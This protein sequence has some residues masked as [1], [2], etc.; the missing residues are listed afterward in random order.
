MLST[1]EQLGPYRILGPIGAGG[2]GEVYKASDTRLERTVAL[3]LLPAHWA[4]NLE[5]RQRFE[6]EAQIVASLNHPNICILHDI[7]RH[8]GS[9]FLVMEYLEGETLA[10]RIERGHIPWDEALHIAIA[11]ADALDKAHR[12]GVVHRDLKP[13]NIILAESGPKLLDFGLAKWN[14]PSG[15]VSSAPPTSATQM[16]TRSDVTMP[17]SIMGTLQYMAPEQLEG[18][19]TDA[20]TDIFAFGSI[21]QEMLT[22]KK[23]FEGKSRVLLMS[24]IASAEPE[25]PSQTQPEIP[26]ALEHIL[27]VC[28]AKEPRDRWQTT[29]DLLAEL[30]WVARAG[31]DATPSSAAPAARGRREWL[32][33]WAPAAAVALAA[34]AAV[35]AALS[36]RATAPEEIRFHVPISTSPRPANPVMAVV[37]G[38][39]QN[40]AISPDGRN[41]VYRAEDNNATQAAA[42]FLRLTGSTAT[43]RLAGTENPEQ[44]FW[45]ADS[46]FVGYAVGSKLFKVEASGG[47]PQPICEAPGFA[48]AAWNREGVILFATAGGLSRVSAEGGKPEKV[49][50]MEPGESAHLWPLFLPDGHHYLFTVLSADPAKHGIFEGDLASRTKARLLPVE[51]NAFYAEPGFLVFGRQNAVYAQPFSWKSAAVSGEPAR[52]ADNVPKAPAGRGTFSVS[53]DGALA[54][55]QVPS[56]RTGGSGEAQEWQAAWVDRTGLLIDEV[57]PSGVW[58]GMEPSPDGKRVAVHRHESSAGDVLVLE[59]RGSVTKLTFDATRHNH[60]PV[61]SPDG[62]R[63]VY[64]AQ[65]KN[66]WGIYQ[67]QSS[68]VGDEEL[69]Y[70]SDQPK[71]PMSWSP[72]GKRI[73]FWTVDAKN[74]GDLWVLTLDDRKAAPFLTTEFNETHAQISP[75]GRWIAYTSNSTGREEIYVQPFPAG[76]GRWQVSFH[77]GDWPRWRGDSKEL[78]FHTLAASLDVPAIRNIV[79][80]G[81]LFAAP[82]AVNGAALEPGTPQAVLRAF[83]N[84][85]PHEP[86]DYQTYGVSADGKRFLID[87]IAGQAATGGGGAVT[88]D[89]GRPALIVAMHWAGSLQ[90]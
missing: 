74:G 39:G 59:P 63:I 35:P 55:F 79:R 62:S 4:D 10:E 16:V 7:G 50:E 11:I 65:V 21:L 61:W 46:R 38:A 51:S 77:G 72:D 67:K 8:E 89:P 33:R 24:A 2:M 31:A 83:S 69:L 85:V 14:I 90:K 6:R 20:R 80:F 5:M 57:G 19:D 17:G 42:L 34:A 18:M 82:I 15:P 45:S 36:L 87:Q 26:P 22:G 56:V 47:P 70:E 49:T 76:A 1:G 40:F 27:R 25:A 68:G 64:S 23:A 9:D 60:S 84:N 54:Y 53:L 43:R 66:K 12:R 13:S 3:K 28:L 71:A 58:F 29:R 81:A 52:L 48:G 73:V 86:G 78:Y 44:P 75:D 41:L 37:N 32:W 30:E 88:P